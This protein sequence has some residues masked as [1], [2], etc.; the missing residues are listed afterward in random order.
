MGEISGDLQ[1]VLYTWS[2]DS[3]FV[4]FAPSPTQLPERVEEEIALHI[5]R[6]MNAPDLEHVD[7]FWTD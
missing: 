7:P 4:Q 3:S 5:Y 6:S 1:S 2:P